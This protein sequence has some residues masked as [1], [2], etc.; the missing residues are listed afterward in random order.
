MYPFVRFGLAML[1]ARRAAPLPLDGT[2][3][4]RVACL[5]FDI[6]PWG[7]LNNGRTLTLYDLGRVPL[8]IRTGVFAVLRREGWRLTVAGASVRYRRRVRA[9][10]RLTLRSAIAGRDAR[11]L[12]VEQS[13]W[14]GEEAVSAAYFRK[15]AVDA[16]GIVATDRIVAAL[17]RPD[18]APAL[19]PGLAAWAAAE[20]ARPWP[21]GP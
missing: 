16:V 20:A 7:E 13:L 21:P 5:P 9:F 15:A 14:R 8:A 3:V 12:Y 10:E 1:S 18:W 19:P 17:G 4:T 11:F 6:D 2:H